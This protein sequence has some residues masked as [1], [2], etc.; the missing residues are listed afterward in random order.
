MARR[1]NINSIE[2]K[3]M[4]SG[5]VIRTLSQQQQERKPI[6]QEIKSEDRDKVKRIIES[7][8]SDPVFSQ[9]KKYIVATCKS[10]KVSIQVKSND[11]RAKKLAESLE[12]LF[13]KHTDDLL[14]CFA[15]GRVAFEKVWGDYD[16]KTNLKLYKKL[17]YL[18]YSNTS[19]KLDEDGHFAGIEFKSKD[20]E[21]CLPVENSYWL[22]IDVDPEHPFGKSQYEGA[23]Y[24]VYQRRKALFQLEMN[25]N[26]RLGV[27]VTVARA[28]ITLPN[29]NTK[30]GSK[31]ILDN[32]GTVI[33]PMDDMAQKLMDLYSGGSI[34]LPS[35][36]DKNGNPYFSI[37]S[38]SQQNA[39]APLLAVLQDSE[40]QAYQSFGLNPNSFTGTGTYGSIRE[41]SRS[42]EIVAAG[43]L[44]Q[45]KN[46]FQKFV[47]DPL[48]DANEWQ[49][50]PDIKIT[51]I[52]LGAGD[53]TALTTFAPMFANNQANPMV[54]FINWKA[55]FEQ[56]GL[57][58]SDNFDEE[59][60]RFLNQPAPTTPPAL[61][62]MGLKKKLSV[63]SVEI[64]KDVLD[65]IAAETK[66]RS[67]GI[68]NNIRKLLSNQNFDPHKLD[69]LLGELA[70]NRKQAIL[71]GK[72]YGIVLPQMKRRRLF[73]AIP[74]TYIWEN[75]ADAIKWLH[76]QK[77]ILPEHVEQLLT[78]SGEE[79]VKATGTFDQFI[80]DQLEKSISEGMGHDEWQDHISQFVDFSAYESET[81]QRTFSKR[82][83]LSSTTETLK[84]PALA[85][86]FPYTQYHATMDSRTRPEHAAMDGK[87]FR[88]DSPEYQKAMELLSD[89][90]CR[91]GSS[92][93]SA[94]DAFNAGYKE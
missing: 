64:Q 41:A 88:N 60:K 31:S 84:D 22:S 16:P 63:K 5:S 52:H 62:Q 59:W 78:E 26:H 68:W 9:I 65:K 66:E 53:N 33:S 67:E 27:S 45:I 3:P 94:E 48:V 35:E 61:P 85:A 11:P 7:I 34:I 71:A 73:S 43:L 81:V 75:I 47:I 89:W 36:R 72:V 38:Q 80:K 8:E 20:Y 23:P 70:E 21:I 32:S 55:V 57:P 10:A 24:L 19:M 54:K 28:P 1:R 37:E 17:I 25:W 51:S 50:K 15:Y 6:P 79:A 44:E 42:T 82:A 91:C 12:D 30:L 58:V 29:D 90:N 93:L 69:E 77:V 2:Q 13:R 49:E 74:E 56:N 76:A 87:I 39:N 40:R 14:A 4:I 86:A 18:P 83:M 92:F 46:S